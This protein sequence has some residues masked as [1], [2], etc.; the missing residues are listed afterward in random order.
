VGELCRCAVGWPPVLA[1]AD[2]AA[3]D[4]HVRCRGAGV[5]AELAED[6][7]TCRIAVDSLMTRRSAMPR[8]VRP[9]ARSAST[10]SSRPVNPSV[11]PPRRVGT[12]RPRRRRNASKASHQP[13]PASAR[14][15]T[16]WRPRARAISVTALASRVLPTPA[17]PCRRPRPP[18]GP[19][20]GPAGPRAPPVW[21]PGR[22]EAGGRHRSSGRAYTGPPGPPARGWWRPTSGGR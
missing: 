4:P 22:G 3:L 13:S 2:Q 10:S 20:C 21:R 18:A 5:D 17:S 8:F 1:R 6:V 7:A 14:P 12:R 15:S 9:A 11:P 16:T 19:R